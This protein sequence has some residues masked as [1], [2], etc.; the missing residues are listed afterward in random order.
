MTEPEIDWEYDY[1]E[2]GYRF[3]RYYCTIDKKTLWIQ[4]MHNDQ[5]VIIGECEHYYWENIGNGCYPDEIDP[6]I[7]EGTRETVEKSVKKIE[8]S[9]STY[10][11]IPKDS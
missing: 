9:S 7:C 3:R 5:E 11:L 1:D 2:E 8:E 10:F 4:Y 6:Q